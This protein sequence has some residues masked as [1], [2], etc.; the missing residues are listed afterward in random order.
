MSLD[1][2]F[3]VPA[4]TPQDE[5]ELLLI[6][7]NPLV[8]KYLLIMAAEDTKEYLGL[9]TLM[10]SPEHLAASHAVLRG[11]LAVLATLSSLAIKST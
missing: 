3:A 7:G 9:S 2:L 1:N 10:V 11:K 8:T 4:L 5:A 6:F